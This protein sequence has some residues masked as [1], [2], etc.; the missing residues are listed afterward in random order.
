MDIM[1]NN[2]IKHPVSLYEMLTDKDEVIH[3]IL[4]PKL[5]RDYAQGREDMTSLRKRF[6]NNIFS[7]IDKNSIET[8]T[9]D[10][11][12][13]QKEEKTKVIFYPVDGQQRLTTLFLLHIYIGKR[14]GED[15]EFLRK[16]SYETRDSSRNFCQ[17][18]HEISSEEYNGI[19]EQIIRQ[20]WYTGLWKNDP[21]IKAM[22]NMLNDI[23]EHYRA[24]N[25]TSIQFKEVW[26]QLI[27]NVNFWLLYLSDLKTTDDLYIKM[28]S[29]GKSLTD[30][31]HFKAMLDEYAGTAGEL[32][33]KIDTTWT[34]LLWR[35]RDVSQDFDREKYMNNG[36]D[37]CFYNLLR[38]YLNIEGTKRG[39]INYQN[40]IEDILEL[41]DVVLSF[42]KKSN[43]E[44]TQSDEKEAK[45]EQLKISCEIMKRFSSILDFFAETD[46][47][48]NYINDPQKFFAKYIDPEYT[49][50]PASPNDM[51]IPNGVKVY[52]DS[53]KIP[54]VDILR[55]ICQSSKMELKPT[56]Y[57]EAFFQYA[58]QENSDS[59]FIDRL[60]ILRNLVENAELH[61]GNFRDNL[62]LVDELITN[63]NMTKDGINDEFTSK[64]KEQEKIKLKW[65][66]ANDSYSTLMK[67]V[68]NHKLLV[69]NLYMVMNANTNGDDTIDLKLL[70]RFG[71]LF[72]SDCDYMEIEKALLC[73]G[74]YAPRKNNVRPYGGEDWILWKRNIIG[75]DDNNTRKIIQDFLYK[76]TDYSNIRLNNIVDFFLNNCEA[77]TWCYYMVKYESIRNATK[78]KFRYLSG[79]YSYLKLN[80]NGGGR[81]EKRWNPFNLMLSK[82]LLPTISNTLDD[83][84]GSLNLHERGFKIDIL[85]RNIKIE[86]PDR[87]EEIDIPVDSTGCLDSVDRVKFAKNECERLYHNYLADSTESS[88][89]MVNADSKV[90]ESE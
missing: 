62:L 13:G 52:I 43:I 60:R 50:W 73:Y 14:A 47:S 9:L 12:F 42:H 53:L 80:A 48:G 17:K 61:A 21:T 72:H 25:Y 32:S 82:L 66:A 35:Y 79:N 28:N 58:S 46:V 40:P 86:Y 11:V 7:V 36:L 57:A 87:T 1:E 65:I 78:S 2:T 64:Q 4:I 56:L 5:Q 55:L 81:K 54:D 31:E 39:L 90:W 85:E 29:R 18:L 41:A 37:A 75:S 38:F 10:F 23:D 51:V 74:D 8:L 83:F 76:E 71:H 84:G 44:Y 89:H 34:K 24:L 70:Q 27:H 63:G 68:E 77:Y 22:I 67:L 26:N 33:N 16:F 59:A 19:K 69:G 88:A 45:E 3:K 49:Y 20:W 30:F 6:L 15:T